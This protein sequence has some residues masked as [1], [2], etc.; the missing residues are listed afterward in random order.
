MKKTPPV[1]MGSVA[2]DWSDDAVDAMWYEINNKILSEYT[3][4]PMW[5]TTVTRPSVAISLD[6]NKIKGQI[7]CAKI[8]A[9]LPVS[10]KYEWDVATEYS[11]HSISQRIGLRLRS[12]YVHK[13]PKDNVDMYAVHDVYHLDQL[14]SDDGYLKAVVDKLVQTLV[15]ELARLTKEKLKHEHY[16]WGDVHDSEEWPLAKK[17]GHSRLVRESKASDPKVHEE[18]D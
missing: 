6:D 8:K 16:K 11:I 1:V 10:E 7:L 13:D 14:I 5:G 15:H 9:L 3:N 18:N 17:S 2:Y 4:P 12:M